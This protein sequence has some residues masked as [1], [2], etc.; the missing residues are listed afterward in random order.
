MNNPLY[1]FV[2][3]SGSGKTTMANALEEICLMNQLQSYTTRP[4]RHEDESGH[5]FITDEEFDELVGIIA[6]TEYSGNR[7]CATK[8][9]ID[10]SDIYVIDVP[11]VQVLLEKYNSNRNIVILYFDV[12]KKTRMAR[13]AARQDS[14]EKINERIQNDE[15]SNWYEDLK[16]IVFEACRDNVDLISVPAYK[17][18]IEVIDFILDCINERSDLF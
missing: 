15:L 14:T 3:P 8:D 7:Y 18:E 5:T 4:P 11:G 17:D 10:K 13:M 12:D 16:Q 2:G 9:Q 6:Y 1:L